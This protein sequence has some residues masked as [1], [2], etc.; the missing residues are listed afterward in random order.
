[1]ELGTCRKLRPLAIMLDTM[2]SIMRAWRWVG[3][4]LCR[5]MSAI[6]RLK[7][8][9]DHLQ[10]PDCLRALEGHS[11]FLFLNPFQP[12]GPEVWIFLH[13]SASYTTFNLERPSP[14]LLI[15]N[16][17]PPWSRSGG[18]PPQH[19]TPTC[20]FRA[21]AGGGDLCPSYVFVC[22]PSPLGAISPACSDLM[23][24]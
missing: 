9:M 8:S 12:K 13:V 5:V 22:T 20:A 3:V 24:Q 15:L 1:M 11:S 16:L 7:R 2:A 14:V 4:L 10:R 19:D 6:Q 23:L 17:T 21:S 18:F